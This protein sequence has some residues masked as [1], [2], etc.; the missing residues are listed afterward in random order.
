M[1]IRYRAARGEF[2]VGEFRH[3]R[4][5]PVAYFESLADAQEFIMQES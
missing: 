2:V 4:F 3:G 1:T 5:M